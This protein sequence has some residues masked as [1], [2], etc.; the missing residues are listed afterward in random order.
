MLLAHPFFLRT[1]VAKPCQARI[2]MVESNKY[3]ACSVRTSL[4]I[5]LDSDVDPD[6]KIA[7]C[8][9]HKSL[10]NKKSEDWHGIFDN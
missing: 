2:P 1:P 8:N 7:I 4:F 5:S 10:Y 3:T 6:A 9:H